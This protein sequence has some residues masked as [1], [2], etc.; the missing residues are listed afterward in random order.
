MTA[1]SPIPIKNARILPLPEWYLPK[2][3]MNASDAQLEGASSSCERW[4]MGFAGIV[5]VS[6]IAELIIAWAQPSYLS[7]LTYSAVADAAVAI[8]IAGEVLIGTIWNN[9]IQTELR[10]RS[11]AQL[12]SAIE[13]AAEAGARAAEA[14]A[15]AAEANAR[16]LDARVELA[17]LTTPRVLTAE[18]HSNVTEAAKGFPGIPFELYIQAEPEPLNLATQIAEALAAGGW[19]WQAVHSTVSLQQPGKPSIGMTRSTGVAFLMETSKRSEWEAAVL[20]V[21]NVLHLTGIKTEARDVTDG[22]VNKSAVRI[23]VGA[24]P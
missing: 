12:A 18:Q 5:V 14:T 4:G 23:A 1:P 15:Q 24:K 13:S 16:A 8:G 10:R 3:T 22:S 19:V 7:F 9:H 20:A 2:G 11:N 21:A 17:R 6:V